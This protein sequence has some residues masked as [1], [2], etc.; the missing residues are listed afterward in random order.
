MGDIHSVPSPAYLSVI[1][2]QSTARLDFLMVWNVPITA[3]P[4]YQLIILSKNVHWTKALCGAVAMT[5]SV[6][7][8]QKRAHDCMVAARL[9]ADRDGQFQWQV[10]SEAWLMFAGLL[11][12]AKSSSNEKP[13]AVAGPVTVIGDRKRTSVIENGERLR[14]RLAL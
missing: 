14:A 1:C 8:F 3:G 9:A 10:L 2:P 7:D 6:A 4:M 5:M 12:R 11:G 13:V